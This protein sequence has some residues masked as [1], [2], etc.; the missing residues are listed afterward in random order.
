MQFNALEFLTKPRRF[1]SAALVPILVAYFVLT[2]AL[3]FEAVVPSYKN[4]STS[5]T[6]AVDSTVYTEIADSLRVGSDDPLLL[7]SMAQFPNNLWTP[8]F[9]SL[10]LSSGFYVMLFN[11]VLFATSVVLLKRTYSI[12]LSVLILLLLLN[13]TTTTSVLCVN[14]E[15]LDLLVISLF[16]YAEKRRNKTLILIALII[17]VLNRYR[18]LRPYRCL[19]DRQKPPQ[20]MERTSSDHGSFVVG[21]IEFHHARL[22]RAGA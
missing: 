22:G 18:D 1:M 10:V 17:A 21:S 15:V 8:V 11:Y 5:W 4:G 7:A 6:F 3:Y 14:K 12:S 19:H 9:I 20:P 2:L 13:P 16:L